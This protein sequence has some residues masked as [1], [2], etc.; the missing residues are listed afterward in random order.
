MGLARDL[1]RQRFIMI[2][3]RGRRVE[4]EVELVLPAECKTRARHGVVAL[5][6]T[7][8]SLGHVGGMGGDL[9]GDA[10][11]LDVGGVRQA[12][13]LA[14]RDVNLRQSVP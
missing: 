10:A 4:R 14:G 1:D 5:S 11:G 6:R 12:Q 2:A 3:A 7:R 13:V 9:V 8:V